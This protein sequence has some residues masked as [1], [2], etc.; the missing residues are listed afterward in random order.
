MDWSACV[1]FGA[2][3]S[4]EL[5]TCSEMWAL[6]LLRRPASTGQDELNG[7]LHTAP[8]FS[9]ALWK[10]RRRSAVHVPIINSN[11]LAAH[12]PS[13]ELTV[14]DSIDR[15]KDGCVNNVD[16]EDPSLRPLDIGRR[17]AYPDPASTAS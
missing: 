2:E 5:E 4:L 15:T 8:A 9:Y 13:G 10:Q 7:L 11:P 3:G 12:F 1:V 17:R 14:Q 6:G 16:C